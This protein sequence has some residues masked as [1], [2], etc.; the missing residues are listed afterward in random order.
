[1]DFRSP[2]SEPSV[3]PLSVTEGAEVVQVTAM[4]AGSDCSAE[5]AVLHPPQDH[6]LMDVPASSAAAL[7]QAEVQ[8]T[9]PAID[10]VSFWAE[11]NAHKEKLQ[12]TVDEYIV[13]QEQLVKG[14][15]LQDMSTIFRGEKKA[16]LNRVPSC[17]SS[18]LTGLSPSWDFGVGAGSPQIS[19][20]GSSNTQASNFKSGS[21][22]MRLSRSGGSAGRGLSAL[23]SIDILG[24]DSEPSTA[25]SSPRPLRSVVRERFINTYDSSK[26]RD[27]QATHVDKLAATVSSRF[28]G[29]AAD[30][31]PLAVMVIS[32]WHSLKEPNHTSRLAKV[33][34]HRYFDLV[35]VL[36]ILCNA[37]CTAWQAN[38]EMESLGSGYGPATPLDLVFVIIYTLELVLKLMVHRMYFFCN[39]DMF[40]NVTFARSLRLFK[41]GKILRIFRAMRL[42]KE[43]RVMLASIV[44]SCSSLFWSFVMI[45]MILFIFSLVF[46]QQ[47][48]EQ[49]STTDPLTNPLWDQQRHYFRNVER[50]ILTLLESTMGGL[51]WDTIYLLVAPLGWPYVWLFIFYIAFFN[52]ALIN[53]L[54]G[55]FVENAMKLAMPDEQE[56]H[57]AHREQVARDMIELRRIV[58]A[59]DYDGDGQILKDEFVMLASHEEVKRVFA[60]VGLDLGNPGIFFHMIADSDSDRFTT[61]QFVERAVHMKGHASSVDLQSLIHQVSVV[62]HA[63]QQ[64]RAATETSFKQ[65]DL[66]R[67]RLSQEQELRRL[68]QEEQKWSKDEKAHQMHEHGWGDGQWNANDGYTGPHDEEDTMPLV[69][70]EL[71]ERRGAEA[72]ED[73][74]RGCSVYEQPGAFNVSNL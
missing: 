52:F 66:Q 9:L 59:M 65:Q 38:R 31:P 60:L 32:W 33:V 19:D 44:G 43:L 28:K 53:I 39:S 34:L 61:E 8:T 14:L 62:S 22:F 50:T 70:K 67:I 54:T 30:V 15:M 58:L 4:T 20:L 25:L 56:A 24:E 37:I 35:I 68:D 16:S 27:L 46:I 18:Q 7:A 1:M 51:D 12:C 55:I 47:M 29:S 57:Q 49:L 69:D 26:R 3:P 41:M 42:M 17:S 10:T 72:E 63:L 71:L 48:T 36:V 45:G 64:F 5:A 6:L 23:G 21:L 13:K 40:G 2:V 73:D 11:W 74:E